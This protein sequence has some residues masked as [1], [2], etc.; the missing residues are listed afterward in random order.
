MT[1]GIILDIDSILLSWRISNIII[2][3]KNNIA[4]AP[5]Y[6]IISIKGIKLNPNKIKRIEEFKKTNTNQ[7]T[8]WIGFKEDITITAPKS[9]IKDKKIYNCSINL[10]QGQ[11]PLPPLCYDLLYL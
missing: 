5:T 7:N 1:I 3:N 8:E 11:V 2:T 10:F 4:I 6:T 9:V